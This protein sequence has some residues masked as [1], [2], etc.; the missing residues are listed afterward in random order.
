MLNTA[1][2]AAVLATTAMDRARDFYERRLGLEPSGEPMPG[3]GAVLYA[4]G[5]GTRLLVYERANAGDSEATSANFFVDDVEGTV[6]RL[7]ANGVAFE[8]YDMGDIKTENGIATTGDF[9]AAWFK[10][11]DG[12]ILCVSSMPS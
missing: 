3:P 1:P 12:N 6:D 2:I 7:R 10:D 5:E 9:K 8:D 4:C 11:P